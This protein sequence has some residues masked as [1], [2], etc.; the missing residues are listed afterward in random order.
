MGVRAGNIV[1]IEEVLK[2]PFVFV[3]TSAEY[4]SGVGDWFYEHVYNADRFSQ[5]NDKSLSSVLEGLEFVL[6]LFSKPNVYT[7]TGVGMEFRHIRDI[8][9]GKLKVLNYREKNGTGGR[10]QRRVSYT[11]SERHFSKSSR[12]KQLLEGICWAYSDIVRIAGKRKPKAEK[13]MSDALE[14]ILN[15]IEDETHATRAKLN[16]DSDTRRKPKKEWNLRTD[17]QI[18]AAAF[19]NSIVNKSPSTILTRDSDIRRLV[20]NTAYYLRSPGING[21][22]K[23]EEL[24]IK[25]PVRV[26]FRESFDGAMLVADTS[27]KKLHESLPERVLTRNNLLVSR[28]NVYLQGSGI[29]E[30]ALTEPAITGKL[31]D[32]LGKAVRYF[33]NLL[34]F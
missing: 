30:A 8:V 28:I 19:Y 2:A 1:A 20:N 16:Y 24:L 27:D 11:Q 15:G 7:V 9:S 3:D 23:L 31:T 34:N 5:I 10:R 4:I 32:M 13:G 26:C 22:K 21:H 14:G 17:E 6:E 33:R 29:Y 12:Q 25:F 18:V